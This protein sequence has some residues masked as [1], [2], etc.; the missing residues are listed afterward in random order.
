MA[1]ENPQV[2]DPTGEAELPVP[3]FSEQGDSSPSV[4][5]DAIVN[6]VVDRLTP[7]L[8]QV[9]E[10]KA[11]SLQDKRFNKIEK[12]LGLRSGVL[13]E[14]ESEGVTIPQEVRTRM[15]IRE[16]REQVAQRDTQ[17]ESVRDVGPSQQKTAVTEAIAS[18]QQYGLEANDPGFIEI[19]RGKY[20]NKAEFDN[21]VLGHIVSKL[22]PPKPANVADVI[23]SPAKGGAT[24]KSPEALTEEYKNKVRAARGNRTEV[25][26]LRNE[27]ARQGVPVHEVDFS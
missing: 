25:A 24:E 10:R 20:A 11:K 2:S 18:L 14:L 26:R 5:V 23:Q 22:A 4:D 3:Q 13:A 9:A 6:R 17:P 19:L 27:Y 21:K 7:Q 8:E 15:E 16:L 12:E 1:N